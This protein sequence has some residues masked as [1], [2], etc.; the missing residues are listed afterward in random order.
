MTRYFWTWTRVP[1]GIAPGGRG[2][3]FEVSMPTGTGGNVCP[4]GCC[5]GIR[6]CLMADCIEGVRKGESTWNEKVHSAGSGIFFW[7]GLNAPHGCTRPP[8]N[9]S[10]LLSPDS[11]RSLVNLCIQIPKRTK[12]YLMGNDRQMLR[13]EKD[14]TANWNDRVCQKSF[15]NVY[16]GR[17]PFALRTAAR[18]AQRLYT[19][20]GNRLTCVS[21]VRAWTKHIKGMENSC[22]SLL[23]GIRNPRCSTTA[24]VV[25]ALRNRQRGRVSDDI[26]FCPGDYGLH[27]R[28]L[29]DIAGLYALN[30]T[31]PCPRYTM[32]CLDFEAFPAAA[33]W[34]LGFDLIM[35]CLVNFASW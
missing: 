19:K 34:W 6:G 33:V 7:L 10:D 22:V 32:P 11:E 23:S 13:S 17:N 12:Y 30:R 8:Q 3:E 21:H 27:C 24:P 1:L 29:K 15:R 16:S 31:N 14:N 9:S 20:T 5:S 4:T 26:D 28:P 2:G 18:L 25:V 35:S